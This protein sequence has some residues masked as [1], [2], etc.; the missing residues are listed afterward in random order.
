MPLVSLVTHP[1][2]WHFV[3]HHPPSP[4][5]GCQWG[6]FLK[7]CNPSKRQEVRGVCGYGTS[8]CHSR[9]FHSL[10]ARKSCQF[11]WKLEVSRGQKESKEWSEGHKLESLVHSPST[12]FAKTV[13]DEGI[14]APTVA[15]RKGWGNANLL[16]SGLAEVAYKGGVN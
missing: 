6:R 16:W 11:P 15:V 9:A 10:W 7:Q 1:Q 5:R 2:S 12:H 14:R 3:C 13:L 8:L 4:G